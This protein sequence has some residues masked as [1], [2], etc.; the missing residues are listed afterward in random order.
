[1]YR[2]SIQLRLSWRPSLG[3][4]RMLSYKIE[5]LHLSECI[6]GGGIPHI[7]NRWNTHTSLYFYLNKHKRI[8]FLLSSVLSNPSHFFGFAAG[9]GLCSSGVSKKSIYMHNITLFIFWLKIIW[10]TFFQVGQSQL[11]QLFFFGINITANRWISITLRVAAAAADERVISFSLS[12]TC[13]KVG[14]G[15]KKTKKKEELYIPPPAAE[16][17]RGIWPS[18]VSGRW[19]SFTHVISRLQQVNI[20]SLSLQSPVS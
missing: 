9:S 11:Q 7:P 19:A 18:F 3:L 13:K 16:A 12:G 6:A 1:M 5:K 2:L 4:C 14:G 20:V 17:K 10:S 8:L 15:G